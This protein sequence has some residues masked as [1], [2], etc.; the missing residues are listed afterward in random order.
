MCIAFSDRDVLTQ[1]QQRQI[2]IQEQS[3]RWSYAKY[4]ECSVSVLP[5]QYK[6]GD[7]IMFCYAYRVDK[8]SMSL[9]C[10]E[11]RL[12]IGPRGGIRDITPR[13]PS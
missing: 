10:H 3:F 7:A 9:D 5:P 8:A 13:R 11:Q 12:K 1:S 6:G 4:D 2:D